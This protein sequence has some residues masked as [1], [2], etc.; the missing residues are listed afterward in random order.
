[1]R[2][3]FAWLQE[4]VDILQ[5]PA[6]IAKRLAMAGLDVEALETVRP[7]F[8]DV[9]IGRVA[10]IAPHPAAP[11]HLVVCQVEDGRGRAA[12][13]CGAPNVRVGAVVPY[14]R[15]G[16]VLPGD[17]P[18][19]AAEIKGVV[20]QGM[21]CSEA[22]LG[23]GEDASSILLLPED[24]PIGRPLPQAI[25]LDDA[26][27][28]VAVTPNRG[29]CL[30]HLGIAR[31]VAALTGGSLK[32]MRVRVRDAGPPVED[33]ASV[34]ILDADLCP[35]YVA[36]VLL[37]VAVGPSPFWMRRRLHLLGQRPINTIVDVTNYV[38][39]ELGQPLHAFEFDRLFERRIVVRRARPGEALTTLD[40]RAR[41]LNPEMLVIADAREAVA[42]AGVMGGAA[43]EVGPATQNILLESANFDP[44]SIR[45]TAKALGVSTEASYRFERGV[46][47]EGAGRA[48]DRAAALM[49]ALAGGQ[50]ARGAADRYVGRAV[51]AAVRLRVSRTND[52]LGTPFTPGEITGALRDLGLRVTERGRDSL[53]VHVPTFRRDLAREIDLIEEVARIRGFDKIPE[54]LPGGAPAVAA[55]SPAQRIEATAR[56]VLAAA[57]FTEAVTFSFTKPGVFD[58]F[59][60]DPGDARRRAVTL[61]NPLSDEETILRTMMV[62]SLLQA[63]AVNQDRGRRAARLFEVARV[64]LPGENQ[65]L[66]R[67]VR[68]LAAVAAGEGPS[69]SAGWDGPQRPVDLYDLRGTL[70]ALGDALGTPLE[71]AEG[72]GSPY[73]HPARSARVR[74]AGQVVGAL[75]EI[76]PRVGRGL[77]LE[78]APYALEVNLEALAGLPGGAVRY[79]PLPRFPA[80]GRDVAVMVPDGVTARTLDEAMR[81]SAGSLLESVRVFDA[82]V[83]GT[84]PAGYRSLAFSL[85]YRAPDR[86]LTDAEVNEVHGA[87]LARLKQIPGTTIR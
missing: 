16:A 33:L 72:P 5:T 84:I 24:L 50:V 28:E 15:P 66:P 43:S 57:G 1:M 74:S 86:T 52:V 81:E 53:L 22:E 68:M 63:L 83:G 51:P 38:M 46:D 61:R 34:E 45:R 40:G 48:A 23:L 13:V 41:V 11:E 9:V 65:A 70:E 55:A 85:A 37:G 6:E 80:V 26:I 35:R 75:G 58:S 59:C 32:P 14:A 77:G 87:V 39:L 79:A 76:H 49:L 17:R 27:L 42:L 78:G 62:P 60:L 36:R 10:E 25:P 7:A 3:S 82:Y 4:F 12:V 8:R 44:A 73:F 56:R 31:E 30:S 18:I 21:L 67:E 19:A 69:P 2:V 64:F 29:D 47:R 54:T 71:V 20:S